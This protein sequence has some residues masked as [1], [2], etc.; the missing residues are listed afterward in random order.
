MLGYICENI[1]TAK[2]YL[3]CFYYQINIITLI[4]E[5]LDLIGKEAFNGDMSKVLLI[6]IFANDYTQLHAPPPQVDEI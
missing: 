6:R 5:V 4:I 2:V 1:D 3:Y